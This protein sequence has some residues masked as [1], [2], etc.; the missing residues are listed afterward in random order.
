MSAKP[1]SCLPILVVDDD[2][3][4]RSALRM[5]IKSEGWSC[6]LA[7]SPEQALAALARAEFGLLLADLNYAR[8]TTSGQE[9]LALIAQARAL[10]AQ[11]P[12][13]AMTAW[14]S[15]PLVVQALQGGASDF[16][17]KPWD[18]TRLAGIIR[19]PAGPGREPAPRPTPG[20]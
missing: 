16:I 20:G 19:T 6:E 3:A 18:N 15:V 10:D 12:I 17:E 13:V 11:L 9:G 4:V 14:G 5:F 7:D 2:A 8:D 1:A